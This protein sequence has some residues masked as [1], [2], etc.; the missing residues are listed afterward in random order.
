MTVVETVQSVSVWFILAYKR[1]I[2]VRQISGLTGIVTDTLRSAAVASV[3]LVK[4]RGPE[5]NWALQMGEVATVV[6]I[7]SRVNL[8][9]EM[10]QNAWPLSFLKYFSVFQGYQK[11]VQLVFHH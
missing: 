9:L 1:F 11:T 2:S 7:R 3:Q 10:N 6:T 8:Y 5:R 4:R